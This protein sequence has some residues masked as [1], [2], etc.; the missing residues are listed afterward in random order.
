MLAGEWSNYNH[1]F[2]ISNA[3]GTKP[4]RICLTQSLCHEIKSCIHLRIDHTSRTHSHLLNGSKKPEYIPCNSYM[5]LTHILDECI[6]MGQNPSFTFG[7]TTPP[8]LLKKPSPD[9]IRAIYKFIKLCN[10]SDLYNRY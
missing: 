1:H 10:I 8:N 7:N 2:K 6:I 3:T 5:P 9:K 4:N